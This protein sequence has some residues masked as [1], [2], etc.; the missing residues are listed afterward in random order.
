VAQILLQDLVNP[1]CLPISLGV[2]I[3]IISLSHLKTQRASSKT[4]MQIEVRN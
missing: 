3:V 2:E 1:F 4:W